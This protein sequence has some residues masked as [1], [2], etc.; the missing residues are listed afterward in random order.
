MGH[1]YYECYSALRWFSTLWFLIYSAYWI[2]PSVLARG[3]T[4]K[5][6]VRFKSLSLIYSQPSGREVFSHFYYAVVHIFMGEGGCRSQA[7]WALDW[8]PGGLGFIPCCHQNIFVNLR[9]QIWKSWSNENPVDSHQISLGVVRSW[10]FQ[11]ETQA[12][13]HHCCSESVQ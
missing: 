7:V 9:C 10:V 6:Y 2:R 12:K 11:S 13:Q 1:Y 5:F 4:I 8:R 3:I